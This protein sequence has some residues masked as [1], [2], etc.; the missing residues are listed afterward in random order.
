MSL[1]YK[2]TLDK[3][4]NKKLGVRRHATLLLISLL[5]TGFQIFILFYFT[6]YMPHASLHLTQK[7]KFKHLSLWKIADHLH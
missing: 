4:K 1:L 2:D 3:C 5:K 6:F 7:S